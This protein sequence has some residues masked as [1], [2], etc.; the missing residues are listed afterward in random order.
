MTTARSIIAGALTHH[1][2]RLSP[3][4]AL[5]ADV[6]S[7]ALDA[8]NFIAD[9]WNGQKSFLFREVLTPST[10]ISAASGSLGT[11][12]VGLASG[13]EILGATVA[14]SATLDVPLQPLTMQ[15]YAEISI[16]SLTTY[17]AYYAHDG[18]STVYF[19][20]VPT[21]QTVTLRTKQVVSDFAD[22]DTDY[23]MPKGYKAA[24]A[25]VL[26]EKLSPA[27]LGGISPAVAVAAKSA[28]SR[29]AG[30]SINPAII[31]GQPYAGPVAR[32][33]RGY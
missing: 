24:L 5:D 1:L 30:Q 23:T 27:M 29:I 14:Y 4:E 13:D 3:G 22:L 19:Y 9:E 21:G 25:A 2:N 28:R 10:A 31:G 6:A 12:W 17:P 20:P 11:T 15:Q 33:R 26:A 32:I 18:A 16:K 8:L 7:V